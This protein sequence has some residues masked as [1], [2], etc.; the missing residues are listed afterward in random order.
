MKLLT[1]DGE[2]YISIMDLLKYYQGM[3]VE[4]HKSC[5]SSPENQSLLRFYHM[6]ANQLLGIDIACSNENIPHFTTKEPNGDSKS[7]TERTV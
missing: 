4:C 6:M 2:S 5:D 1:V 3:A 7:P